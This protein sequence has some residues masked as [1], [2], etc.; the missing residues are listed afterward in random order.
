MF[1]TNKVHRLT[2]HMVIVNYRIAYVRRKMYR[3]FK[4]EIYKEYLY[5]TY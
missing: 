5:L 3:V 4:R 2:R 1:V